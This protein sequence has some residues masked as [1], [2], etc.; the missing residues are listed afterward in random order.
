[1][2]DDDTP[3]EVPAKGKEISP[4]LAKAGTVESDRPF[5]VDEIE[6]STWK[7]EASLAD[8]K[9]VNVLTLLLFV[10]ETKGA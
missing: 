3:C 9:D 1:M 2:W 10:M 5:H 8:A 6:G 7:V 4:T